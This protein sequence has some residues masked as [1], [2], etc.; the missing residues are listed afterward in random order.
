[1]RQPTAEPTAAR[2]TLSKNENSFEFALTR[3]ELVA[4]SNEAEELLVKIPVVSY[5]YHV[6]ELIH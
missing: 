2:L 6:S 4:F 5:H 1:M 3:E